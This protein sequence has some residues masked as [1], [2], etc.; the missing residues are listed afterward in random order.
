MSN[1]VSTLGAPPDSTYG[2]T[3][4][5]MNEAAAAAQAVEPEKETVREDFGLVIEQDGR[6]E[7]PVYRM[8]DR[9]TGKVIHEYR[10][11]A[12]LRMREAP[13]YAAGD[14]IKTVA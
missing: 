13:V 5:P 7:H 11:D 14:V 6:D 4:A 1:S 8:V 9:R 3:P 10:R 2:Q 12:V